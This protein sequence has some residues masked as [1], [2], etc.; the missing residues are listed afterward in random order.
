MRGLAD[1]HD[2]QGTTTHPKRDQLS[3]GDE[4]FDMIALRFFLG[5]DCPIRRPWLLGL[6]NP[7]VL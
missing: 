7:F 5:R 3:R 6:I 2:H 4:D 1:A